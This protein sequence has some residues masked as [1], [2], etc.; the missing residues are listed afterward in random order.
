[1]TVYR[2]S[3]TPVLTGEIITNINQAAA[4]I[5][6]TSYLVSDQLYMATTL[7]MVHNTALP[8]YGGYFNNFSLFIVSAYYPVPVV[9]QW[10]WGGR[11]KNEGTDQ[12]PLITETD[13]AGAPGVEHI[14]L[15]TDGIYAQVFFRPYHP[16][17]N[18]FAITYGTPLYY[19]WDYNV[20]NLSFA[21]YPARILSGGQPPNF[22]WLD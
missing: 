18:T 17:I 1:M 5:D 13:I 15:S 19:P 11:W 10:G 3:L 9:G 2:A 14:Q 20:G 6:I 12:Y 7:N 22:I 8:I 4:R 21:I 16:G